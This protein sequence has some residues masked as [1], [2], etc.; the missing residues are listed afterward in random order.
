MIISIYFFINASGN[1]WIDNS[2]DEKLINEMEQDNNIFKKMEIK[3]RSKKEYKDK[4]YKYI[5]DKEFNVENNNIE[6][7]TVEIDD[8]LKNKDLEVNILTEN[9]KVYGNKYIGD[10][11]ELKSNQYKYYVEH[12]EYP[13]NATKEI[14]M[15]EPLHEE[16]QKDDISEIEVINLKDKDKIKEVNIYIKDTTVRVG[17]DDES[18]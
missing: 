1:D 17:K 18:K 5:E 2:W 13:H 16:I 4:I 9:L 6:I 8:N 11:I 14:D 12:N 15:K 7:A 10:N 3:N